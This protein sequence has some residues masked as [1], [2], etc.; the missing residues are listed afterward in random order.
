MTL[1]EPKITDQCLY[2][3]G[4]RQDARVVWLRDGDVIPKTPMG[5]PT[6]AG[7]L[8]ILLAR[9][10]ILSSLALAL[11]RRFQKH[12][13]LAW[14]QVQIAGRHDCPLMSRG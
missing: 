3:M 10:S 6:G 12:L 11:C 14:E 9:L 2:K 1:F 13:E 8:N 5:S 4:N 7:F